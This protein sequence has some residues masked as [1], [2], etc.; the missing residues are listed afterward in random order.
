MAPYGF[1]PASAM[2]ETPSAPEEPMP[3][4]SGVA[5]HA[6]GRLIRTKLGPPRAPRHVVP[7]EQVKRTLA[8]G[9]ERRLTLLRAPAGFGKSTVLA[10][11]RERLLSERRVVA[12]VTLDA[13]DNDPNPFVA[14]LILAL[15]EAL[16][17][18]GDH[19]HEFA[20]QAESASPKVRLTSVI[21]ALDSIEAQVTLILDDYDRI[22]AAAVHDLLSFLLLRAPRNLHVVV[23]ARSEPPL[24]LAWL[25]A[26]DELVEIDAAALRFGFEDTRRF[27]GEASIGLDAHQAR[28]LHEATEGWVAGL[29]IAL[30]ALRERG[31]DA[32][33]L[34]AGFSGKFKAVNA[35]LADAVLPNLDADTVRLL[36]RI[37]VLERFNGP[38]CEAVAGVQDG[39]AQLARL[40]QQ[41]LFLQALDDENRS[42]ERRVGKECRRL[43]RSRW[44]PY[45]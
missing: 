41:N 2:C 5:A 44:S 12:W 10:G 33:R 8:L 21:N 14:Y 22:H 28:A 45:H 29:Q 35:Y 15:S 7:R 11:F 13:D 25:R 24:P 43:C 38:L 3:R 18:L 26:Q 17:S 36:L 40:Y 39:A 1:D 6:A 27:F 34:I 16:G 31:G 9:L 37:S 30:V 19:V 42:E 20:A 4:K 23:A 32:G